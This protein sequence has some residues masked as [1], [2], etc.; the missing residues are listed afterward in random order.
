MSFIATQSLD[1]GAIFQIRSEWHHQLWHNH[2]GFVHLWRSRKAGVW[3]CLPVRPLCILSQG[4][5]RTK[6]SGSLEW[7]VP[8]SLLTGF[9]CFYI[10]H[11]TFLY[12]TLLLSIGF[13]SASKVTVLF[14]NPRSDWHST[15]RVTRVATSPLPWNG[16]TWILF[17]RCAVSKKEKFLG[18]I[19][20]NRDE[21]DDGGSNIK[22]KF[23]SWLCLFI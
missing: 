17:Y 6:L 12:Y 15:R 1:S 9:S 19:C 11:P 22:S 18:P 8:C 7:V 21:D 14:C 20:F 3:A 5:Y 13:G 4:N 10:I 16:I 2:F 23:K